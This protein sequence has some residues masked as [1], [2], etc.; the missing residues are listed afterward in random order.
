VIARPPGTPRPPRRPISVTQH[1]RSLPRRAALV[2]ALAAS[3][4][5]CREPK[6]H[7]PPPPPVPDKHYGD[8][9]AGL[10]ELWLDLV[11]GAQHDEREYVHQLM[12]TMVMTDDDLEA[13]FG[14]ELAAYLRPRY[15]PMIARMVNAGAMELVAQILER[16][17]DDVD[18]ITYSPTSTDIEQRASIGALKTRQPIYAV[19]VKVTGETRGLRYDFFVYRNGRWITGNQIAKLF[20]PPNDTSNTST[21]FV[22]PSPHP[23]APAAGTKP[24]APAGKATSPAATPGKPAA[25]AAPGPD[26]K[27]AAPVAAPTAPAAR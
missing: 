3:L 10:R 20:A 24:A 16:K 11:K 7:A 23:A 6:P 18:I 22:M 17:Y 26:G 8:G 4:A 25:P 27:T 12:Q 1:P 19:R 13:L 14:H 5:C 9:S 2:V 15:A 21:G